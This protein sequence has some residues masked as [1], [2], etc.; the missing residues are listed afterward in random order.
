[1]IS[2]TS[3]AQA[4]VP[5]ILMLRVPMLFRALFR[6]A[7][8]TARPLSRISLSSKGLTL[9]TLTLDLWSLGVP[10]LV[11]LGFRSYFGLGG[12]RA[13][14]LFSMSRCLILEM[15]GYLFL[16]LR[17]GNMKGT[18][19]SSL[20]FS[21][22]SLINA[23]S[24]IS[25][26]L[27]CFSLL[28]SSSMCSSLLSPS[29][30]AVSSSFSTVAAIVIDPKLLISSRDFNYC[31]FVSPFLRWALFIGLRRT[32]FFFT[33]ILKFCSWVDHGLIYIDIND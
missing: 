9:R 20:S 3:T 15:E 27:R 32:N 8:K 2:L 11:F 17:V 22:I 29:I 12:P 31:L 26:S 5:L 30:K 4:Q 7:F 16:S 25:C 23:F 24:S 33:S 13:I 19:S 6:L 14:V 10:C 21:W 18:L 1:M 28:S